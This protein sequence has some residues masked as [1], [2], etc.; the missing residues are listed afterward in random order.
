LKLLSFYQNLFYFPLKQSQKEN[1][2]FLISHSRVC[3]KDGRKTIPLFLLSFSSKGKGKDKKKKV[4][5][6]SLS[7][8]F[9]KQGDKFY[10]V[11]ED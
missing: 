5:S 10:L 9:S 4:K 8:N 6:P 1:P 2:A 11:L 7:V 3:A